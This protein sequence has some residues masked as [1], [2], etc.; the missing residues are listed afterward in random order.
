MIIKNVYQYI[1]LQHITFILCFSLLTIAGLIDYLTGK[2][3]L[4]RFIIDIM[5]INIGL[6]YIFS[7]LFKQ[8]KK[9]DNYKS[10]FNDSEV[11][12]Q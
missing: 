12:Q 1:C 10:I 9:S 11:L 6:S 4:Y 2:I 7:L 3:L 8:S 5:V